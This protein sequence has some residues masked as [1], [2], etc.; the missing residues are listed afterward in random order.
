MTYLIVVDIDPGWIPCRSSKIGCC[1]RNDRY[2]AWNDKARSPCDIPW[3]WGKKNLF[4]R[5]IPHNL[6]NAQ[7]RIDWCKAMLT[8]HVQGA[9]KAIYTIDIDDESLVQAYKP[10]TKQQS[11]V[12]PMGL[13]RR[14]KS[15][16]SCSS[17]EHSETN[18][19]MF[20]RYYRSRC[21]SGV[22]AT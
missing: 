2:C 12:W 15:N 11:T 10:E 3:D 21:D 5:R 4:V 18:G 22:R 8:K 16:K 19:F 6:T 1:A 9:S 17:K 13:P 7:N 20:L 14:A